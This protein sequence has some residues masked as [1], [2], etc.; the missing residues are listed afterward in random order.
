MIILDYEEL[1]PLVLD[2]LK[3]EPETSVIDILDRTERLAINKGFFKDAPTWSYGITTHKMPREDREKTRE[4]IN[5]LVIEGILGW[6]LNERNP[7][8][9]FLKVTTYGQV[10][11]SHAEPQPYDPDG[12]LKYLKSE[13]PNLDET[14][15][16]Y[17]AESLI[18][19]LRGLT[20]SS[21][22][23]LGGASEKAFL[24]LLES[25][26]NAISDPA[27]K[28]QFENNTKGPVKKKFDEFRKIIIQ[29]RKTLP[30]P[31]S[32]DLDIQ[33]DGIFN[34]IRICRNDVGHP[35]GRKIERSLAYANLRLFVPYCKRIYEL[36]DYFKTNNI[37]IC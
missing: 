14:V 34:F 15:T 6:G 29:I 1:R 11:L 3:G 17:I 24:L 30:R 16:M 19:Y 35:T 4:M 18:A 2:V 9:P 20:L 21:T 36:I 28:T 31:L 12:Y 8:P 10:C 22:V 25:F 26:T 37:I 13:I 5:D 33:L 27:K 23:M 32:D 7:G